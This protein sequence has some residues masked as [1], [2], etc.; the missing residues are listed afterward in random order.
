MKRFFHSYDL[1]Y[2]ERQWLLEVTHLVGKVEWV[3]CQPY[4]LSCTVLD[5]SSDAG[6]LVG[7]SLH[8]WCR[9]F[10]APASQLWGASAERH[11]SHC[12]VKHHELPMKPEWQLGRGCHVILSPA[13][14]KQTPSKQKAGLCRHP[15]GSC[16]FYLDF[17]CLIKAFSCILCDCWVPLNTWHIVQ[18]INRRNLG[19]LLAVKAEYPTG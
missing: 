6:C 10:P 16:C 8:A 5:L 19:Y 12:N 4:F 18:V 15:L 7:S 2:K 1:Q 9:I 17:N 11:S 3:W 13:D 14:G